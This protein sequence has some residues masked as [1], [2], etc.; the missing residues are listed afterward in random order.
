MK[1]EINTSEIKAK[2]E[3]CEQKVYLLIL[4]D[5]THTSL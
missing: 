2:F 5:L 4:L 3:N 1:E